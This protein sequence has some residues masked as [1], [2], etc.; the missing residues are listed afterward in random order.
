MSHAGR[1]GFTLVVAMVAAIALFRAASHAQDDPYRLVEGWAQLPDTMN[2]GKWGQVTGVDV[3]TEGN[4]Y[5]LHKCFSNTCVGRTH[6]PILKFD[7][8]GKL[9][10]SWGQGMIP[11][12]HGFHVDRDGFIWATD[13]PIPSDA[14]GEDG[15]GQQVFKFSPDGE[16]VLALGTAGVAGDGPNTFNGPADVAVA[17]NGEIFVADGHVNDRVVKFSR[18]GR[19]IKAWGKEG[20]RPGEFNTPHAIAIDSQGRVVVGDRG[21]NRI[22]IFDQEGNFLDQWKQFGRASGIFIAEDDT[23]YVADADSNAERNPGFKRG[24][25][26]GRAKDGSV[27]AFIEDPLPEPGSGAEGVTADATGNIY[28]AVVRREALRKYVKK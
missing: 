6:P 8:S 11:W 12:P 23:M 4:V 28:V 7:R 20:A 14:R 26:I 3:D 15:K 17:A 2:G 21:N 18:D 22:Q 10:K 16:L 25:W 24:I 19:F 1:V 9:L 27:K 13:A 5:V